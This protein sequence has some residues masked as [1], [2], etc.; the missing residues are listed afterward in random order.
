M[1]DWAV[2]P[3]QRH[4]RLG[5]GITFVERENAL[6]WVD[7]LDRRVNRHA[8]DTG[9]ETGWTLPEMIGWLIE[10][11]DGAGFVAGLESGFHALTLEPFA[12]FRLPSPAPGP[13]NR[14]NDA[15]ADA[16]GRIWA[17]TMSLDGSR[18]EGALFRLDPDLSWRRV[19]GPYRIANGPA[20][21][22]DGRTLYHADSARGLV[23]RFAVRDDGTLGPRTVFLE[24]PDDWGSPDGMT[25]DAQ[26]G[27]WVA[28]W[29][30]GC[31]SRFSPE[32]RR[33]RSIALPASQITRPCF[34]G[35]GMDRMFVT[36]AAEGVNE[37]L[38]GAV[39]EVDPGVRGLP[40]QRFGI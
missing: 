32:G 6:Y 36:S 19:D 3:R 15:V 20:I 27:L 21:A 28:H 17:G 33:E 18:D 34:A 8:L 2:L 1:T 24:F 30:G 7:I 4:D 29:G 31:V 26:G 39:F 35:A 5:E 38:A 12:L 22:P 10:R 40:P 11:K 25:M 13:G 16:R 14:M 23:Y 37:P 9:A